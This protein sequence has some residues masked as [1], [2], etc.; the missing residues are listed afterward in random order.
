MR[1]LYVAMFFMLMVTS[2]M[3][4]Q[5]TNAD[6]VSM[7][8][9]DLA[10]ELLINK[11]KACDNL[12]DVS[13][14]AMVELRKAG[15]SDAVIQVMLSEAQKRQGRRESSI[16]LQIQSLASDIPE[17]RQFAYMHLLR[18]GLPAQERMLDALTHADP[19]VRAAVIDAFAKMEK[20][21]AITMIRVMLEDQ[22][23]IVRHAAA[24][25]LA[26]YDAEFSGKRALKR[27]TAWRSD[28]ASIPID[29][30]IRLIGLTKNK[31]AIS[32]LRVIIQESNIED[33]RIQTAWAIGELHDTDARSILNRLLLQDR[34]P[35]VR[36][37]VAQVLVA[38]PENPDTIATFKHAIEI[39]KDNRTDLL[40]MASLFPEK[41]MVPALITLMAERLEDKEIEALQDSLRRMT[42]QDFGRDVSKWLA[43]WE[44]NEQRLTHPMQPELEHDAP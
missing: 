20:R 1:S 19:K 16:S 7:V 24:E 8:K 25:F 10:Q 42:H 18:M 41:S 26:Q 43:W 17:T 35:K 38:M 3:A 2:A 28:T 11:I 36:L 34:S 39:D 37:M 30:D 40:R 23:A 4:E 33:V 9:A 14:N 15:V 44:E 29:A 13:A 31:E 5:L 21:D 6:I 22:Q 32:A 12:F 27:V